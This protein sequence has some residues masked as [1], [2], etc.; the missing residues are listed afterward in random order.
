MEYY[1]SKDVSITK[2]IPSSGSPII[3]I[4]SNSKLDII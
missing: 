3:F 4:V 2:Y 1:Y